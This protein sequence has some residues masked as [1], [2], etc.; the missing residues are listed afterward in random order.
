M[1]WSPRPL[2]LVFLLALFPACLP[3]QDDAVEQ[4]SAAVTEARKMLEDDRIDDARSQLE[5]RLKAEPKDQDARVLLAQVHS[6]NGG[7]DKA[8][9]TL[10]AGLKNEKADLQLLWYLAHMRT[11]LGEDGPNVTRTRG[12]ISYHPS[13]MSDKE[14]TEWK[15]KQQGLAVEAWR[16][17][18][19]FDPKHRRAAGNAARA[20]AAWKGKGYLEEMAKL[21]E[22]FPDDSGI[23]LS[24]AG[25]L[26]AGGRAGE[27][28]EMARELTKTQPRSAAAWRTQAGVLRA[29]DKKEEAADADKRAGFYDSVPVCAALDYSPE[30][31]FRLEAMEENPAREAG[32]LRADPSALASKLMAV[33]CWRHMA[34]GPV[35]DSCFEELAERKQSALLRGLA[36]EGQS[37]CTH[38]GC[39]L[40]LA[41]MKD[42]GAFEIISGYL[43]EDNNPVFFVNAAT[44]LGVLGDSRA[45]P[46]LVKGLGPSFHEKDRQRPEQEEGFMGSGPLQNR[47]RCGF[48]LG[49]F[50]TPEAKE[51]LKE[52]AKN[53]DIAL[54]CEAALYRLTKDTAHLKA[55][56]KALTAAGEDALM[57]RG[58]LVSL[59]EEMDTPEAKEA[60]VRLT[61]EKAK[62]GGD[63]APKKE[64]AASP[65]K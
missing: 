5:E 62:E 30:V 20:L 25:A 27:A 14:E 10:E 46:L 56:E 11:Q 7:M 44:A 38:R 57:Y 45:V 22:A 18:L 51:A 59:L 37:L 23:S 63:E 60:V 9:A 24:Y 61:K 39:C 3:A 2:A 15:Q 41:K 13:K 48:A 16:K 42:L 47:I 28:L 8:T 55:V 4:E 65:E 49:A 26:A 34:H 54:S 33:L 1:N 29:L 31:V 6:H 36:K 17:F 12:T 53:P 64:E 58:G 35:E 21:K 52:G 19:K 50:D 32:K 40:G 43:A